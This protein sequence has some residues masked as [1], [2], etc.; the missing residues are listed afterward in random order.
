MR[1]I[2]NE[3]AAQKIK[4]KTVFEPKIEDSLDDVIEIIASVRRTDC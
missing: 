4:E 2:E 3:V 1:E